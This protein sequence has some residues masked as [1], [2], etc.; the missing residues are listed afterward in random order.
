MLDWSWKI[1]L[2]SRN[3]PQI[4]AI[5]GEELS[6]WRKGMGHILTVFLFVPLIYKFYE[7]K[8][9]CAGCVCVCKN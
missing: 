7:F 9:M 3:Y 6:I 2:L 5:L 4:F 8:C 1:I